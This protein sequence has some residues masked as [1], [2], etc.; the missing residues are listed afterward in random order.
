MN[1]SAVAEK[2]SVAVR[3][4]SF[5]RLSLFPEVVRDVA[6]VVAQDV[7]HDSIEQ[8][9]RQADQLITKV[10]LFDVYTG[11]KMETGHKSMAYRVTFNSDQRT[12]TSAEVDA[13]E[14]RLKGILTSQFNATL[15]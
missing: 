10:T 3:T 7:T 11:T 2:S 1:L 12:L 14:Q 8:S 6:F 15:R 4:T 13:A 9:L 5:A